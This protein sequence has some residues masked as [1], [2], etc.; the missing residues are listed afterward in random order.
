MW[1]GSGGAAEGGALS[2]GVTGEQRERNI[3]RHRNGKG[4]P[5]GEE[6]IKGHGAG[7]RRGWATE[8]Q[9]EEWLARGEIERWG[10][11]RDK[12]RDFGRCKRGRPAKGVTSYCEFMAMECALKERG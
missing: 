2:E 10:M 6:E 11:L 9:E 12:G 8:T 1:L 7:E 5:G 3:E 4:E